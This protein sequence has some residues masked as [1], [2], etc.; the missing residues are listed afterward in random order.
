M[1]NRVAPYTDL[2]FATT[3]ISTNSAGYTSLN[4]NITLTC[5]HLGIK[6]TATNNV[7]MLKDTDWFKANRICPTEWQ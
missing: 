5:N 3:I 7:T 6:L 2:V 4:G 1:I